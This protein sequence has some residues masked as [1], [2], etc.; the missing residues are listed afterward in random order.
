MGVP[1]RRELAAYLL[2]LE[3]GPMNLGDAIDLV[4]TRLCSNKKTARNIIKR[5]KRIG[6]LRVVR[7]EGEIIVEPLDPLDFLRVLTRGYI[8]A[9]SRRCGDEEGRTR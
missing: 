7:R 1:R 5:L 3:A 9:R 4:R 6:A 2:L 8:E